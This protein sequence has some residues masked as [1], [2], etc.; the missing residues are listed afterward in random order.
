MPRHRYT[1]AY[2]RS[3]KLRVPLVEVKRIREGIAVLE[4][5]GVGSL[6]IESPEG[7]GCVTVE[8]DVKYVSGKG[9]ETLWKLLDA[10]RDIAYAR[11]LPNIGRQ[12]DPQD[13][14]R[15]PLCPPEIMAE[16]NMLAED[17][18]RRLRH[19]GALTETKTKIGEYHFTMQQRERAALD[20]D[21]SDA[22]KRIAFRAANS[23]ATRDLLWLC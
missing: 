7:V 19:F 13:R 1:Q 20:A 9:P 5:L 23:S 2:I 11:T 22:E 12:I 14:G 15:W 6:C 16:M 17:S 3:P 10:E 18:L 8:L 21:L 4:A